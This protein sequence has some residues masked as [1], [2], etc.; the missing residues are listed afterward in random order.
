MKIT[1]DICP[2]VLG[3]WGFVFENIRRGGPE[4]VV[5]VVAVVAIGDRQILFQFVLGVAPRE[6]AVGLG[7]AHV[8]QGA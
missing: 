3:L 1:Y 4:G 5:L 2:R 7:E 8:A 6:V